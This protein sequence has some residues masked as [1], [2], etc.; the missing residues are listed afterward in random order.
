G[1]HFTRQRSYGETSVI[2][3]LSYRPV[4]AALVAAMLLVPTAQELHSQPAAAPRATLQPFDGNALIFAVHASSENVVWASG[5]AGTILR[6]I[7]GGAN[8][9]RRAAPGGDSLQFRDIHGFG[10]DTAF[11]LSIGNGES[12][13]VYR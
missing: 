9:E 8:W 10:P 11:V 7:D 5:T 1:F 2:A 13:R 4:V 3:D 12:S 6:T